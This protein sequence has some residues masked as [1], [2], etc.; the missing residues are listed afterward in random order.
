MNI[1][2]PQP[3]RSYYY[4]RRDPNTIQRLLNDGWLPIRADDP[5]QWGADLPEEVQDSL[6][7]LRAFKDVFLMWTTN[8]NYARIKR[9]KAKRAKEARMGTERGYLE[10][11]MERMRELGSSAPSNRD[12]YYRGN[13]HNPNEE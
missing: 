13:D 9:E 1:K 5:E 2:N 12:L 7:G 10:R 6:D 11:G 4:S 3:G 8:E